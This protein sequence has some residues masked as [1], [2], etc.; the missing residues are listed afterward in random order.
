MK[1]FVRERDKW[2]K[3]MWW[4]VLGCGWQLLQHKTLV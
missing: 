4:R 3:V 2:L 1:K